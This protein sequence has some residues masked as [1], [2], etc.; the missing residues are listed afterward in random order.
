M[1]P[2]M[3][4]MKTRQC[5]HKGVKMGAIFGIYAQ[6]DFFKQRDMPEIKLTRDESN[7]IYK[8]DPI[9][10]RVEERKYQVQNP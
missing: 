4:L 7:V 5:V 3:T 2:Y 8:S 10:M 6:L 9:N 1:E